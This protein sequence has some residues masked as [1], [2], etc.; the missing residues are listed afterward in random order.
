MLLIPQCMPGYTPLHVV[1]TTL[2]QLA[3]G[4][5]VDAAGVCPR[6]CVRGSPDTVQG[7]TAGL[8]NIIVD[9]GDVMPLAI[10]RDPSLHCG[11]VGCCQVDA[12]LQLI[13]SSVVEDHPVFPVVA[14]VDDG[15]VLVCVRAPP[16][17]PGEDGS[18]CAQ[19][20][21]SSCR[22]H[23]NVGASCTSKFDRVPTTRR[24]AV[25]HPALGSQVTG[26]WHRPGVP[27]SRGHRPTILVRRH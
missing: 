4:I 22:G 25:L 5:L 24:P 9:P 13:C 18:T 8:H 21:D 10:H 1:A 7:N 3:D 12:E 19:V 20:L 11:H 26:V 15:V 16:Y 14:V 2:N 6:P 23:V 17:L 27:C